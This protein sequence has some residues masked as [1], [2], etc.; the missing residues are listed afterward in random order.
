[1][2]KYHVASA[3]IVAICAFARIS[4]AI[5]NHDGSSTME[6]NASRPRIDIDF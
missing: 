5:T 2:F 1:M 6:N 3:M 4:G